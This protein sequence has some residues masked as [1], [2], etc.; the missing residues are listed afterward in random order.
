MDSDPQPSTLHLEN[1]LLAPRQA[2]EFSSEVLHEWGLDDQV[3]LVMLL[4]SELV[5]NSVR[6]TSGDITLRLRKDESGL[7]VEVLDGDDHLP[8]IERPEELG[9]RG[10]G[11]LL[12]N[13]LSQEWGAQTH[14]H[15]KSVWLR[16]PSSA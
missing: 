6:Y 14:D 5:T 12:I 11:L 13:A 10:R 3:D 15:G 16:L 7:Y 4:V 8:R 9:E 2:R 1:T